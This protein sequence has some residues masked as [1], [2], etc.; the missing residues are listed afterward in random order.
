MAE[1]HIR[2]PSGKLV[3]GRLDPSGISPVSA[4][5]AAGPG[6]VTPSGKYVRARQLRERKKK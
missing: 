6:N 2:L 1:K 3:A 5:W 4:Q